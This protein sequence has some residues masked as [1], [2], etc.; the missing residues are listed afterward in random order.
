[1]PHSN[2]MKDSIRQYLEQTDTPRLTEY[3]D[4][5]TDEIVDIFSQT[6]K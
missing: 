2:T 6:Q 3:V 1:M 4:E 5:C